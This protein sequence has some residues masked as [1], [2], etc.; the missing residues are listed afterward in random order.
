M[1][2]NNVPNENTP[3]PYYDFSKALM[4]G[5]AGGD[6]LNDAA[7]RNLKVQMPPMDT[8]AKTIRKK[9]P[10]I[11]DQVIGDYYK[12][13]N[14]SFMQFQNGQYNAMLTNFDWLPDTQENRRQS[15]E[16]V[17]HG[18]VTPMPTDP[19][20]TQTPIGTIKTKTFDQAQSNQMVF[21]DNGI[22]KP[23]SE[24]GA[25]GKP[26]MGK[27]GDGIN[28][29][30]HYWETINDQ[31]AEY[32]DPT[33]MQTV[34]GDRTM[35]SNILGTIGRSVWSGSVPFVAKGVAGL[36]GG[37]NDLWD[38]MAGKHEESGS[39]MAAKQLMNWGNWNSHMN[40]D[41]QTGASGFLYSVGSIAGMIVT[42]WGVSGLIGG[43][44]KVGNI[45]AGAATAE[46]LGTEGAATMLGE[47][48][49]LKYAGKAFQKTATEKMVQRVNMG[50]MSTELASGAT[51]KMNMMGI[52][53]PKERALVY[54]PTLL[55]MYG[56]MKIL[57]AKIIP[58]AF[59]AE[60]RA[61]A[62]AEMKAI[63]GEPIVKTVLEKGTSNT[64]KE[65]IGK[66]IANSVLGIGG[67]IKKTAE[68]S[69]LGKLAMTPVE[70]TITV[71]AMGV[72]NYA[73]ETVYNTI[74]DRQSKNIISSLGNNEYKTREVEYG[75]PD[76]DGNKRTRTE[77]YKT[78]SLGTETIM[79]QEL[80]EAE[81]SDIASA[82]NFLEGPGKFNPTENLDV[83]G[84]GAPIVAS[85]LSV[86][87][88]ELFNAFKAKKNIEQKRTI[89]NLA[90][91]FL[92]DP[93]A[94]ADWKSRLKGVDLWETYVDAEGQTITSD[95][96]GKVPSY[97]EVMKQDL[98]NRIEYKMEIIRKYGLLGSEATS[99]STFD[100][101][102]ETAGKT[103]ELL[104][105]YEKQKE[106]HQ[107]LVDEKADEK[108]VIKSQE[109]LDSYKKDID[110]HMNPKD[111]SKGMT[112]SQ[113]Y[114]DAVNDKTRFNNFLDTIAK[115]RAESRMRAELTD[116]DGKIDLME[117]DRQAKFE[118]SRIIGSGNV[119]KFFYDE[120]KK[121]FGGHYFDR[122]HKEMSNYFDKYHEVVNKFNESK[123]VTDTDKYSQSIEKLN[124]FMDDLSSY[125][126]FQRDSK[127]NVVLNPE[128][129]A[130]LSD[131]G[132]MPTSVDEYRS[133]MEVV[134][135]NIK[136]RI[137]EFRHT[138]SL[139]DN[140]PI[141]DLVEKYKNIITEHS[142]NLEDASDDIDIMGTLN[143]LSG[144]GG[145][146]TTHTEVLSKLDLSKVEKMS[147]FKEMP[148]GPE[149]E[150][151]YFE[152]I[153]KLINQVPVAET[154]GVGYG[155][156]YID[157][158]HASA[159]TSADPDRIIENLMG[160][161]LTGQIGLK[162]KLTLFK[163][164]LEENRKLWQDKI[165]PSKKDWQYSP[166]HDHPQTRI[167]NENYDKVMKRIDELDN[168]IETTVLSLADRV[169]TRDLRDMKEGMA[170]FSMDHAALKILIEHD[171]VLLK[172]ASENVRNLIYGGYEKVNK[173]F[174]DLLTKYKVDLGS[175]ND[176]SLLRKL[177]ELFR[178]ESPDNEAK[179]QDIRE[180]YNEASKIMV[181]TYDQLGNGKLS[182]VIDNIIAN[183]KNQSGIFWYK[184]DGSNKG[185]HRAYNDNHPKSNIIPIIEDVNQW[186]G[187]NTGDALDLKYENAAY[188][189]RAWYMMT[190]L[191]RINMAGKDGSPTYKQG[192]Q[193][194]R[195]I[196]EAGKG[197][198]IPNSGQEQAIL[199][200]FMHHYNPV[201]VHLDKL[202][203]LESK[204]FQKD[205]IPG[206]IEVNGY[207]SAGKT[208][209]IPRT[210]LKMIQ[211]FDGYTDEPGNRIK[212][213]VV[214]PTEDLI[215]TH[216]KNLGD[217]KFVDLSIQT[218][219]EFNQSKGTKQTR[220]DFDILIVDEGSLTTKSTLTDIK[221]NIDGNIPKL[222]LADD[223]Q[224]SAVP[225]ILLP[226]DRIGE[227][228]KAVTQL[229][230]SGVDQLHYLFD[231]IRTIRYNPEAKTVLANKKFFYDKSDPRN[232]LGV[233]F[234]K[235]L[236]TVKINF[237]AYLESNPNAT[238]EDAILIVRT[239][240]ERNDVLAEINP[241]DNLTKYSAMVKTM[242]VVDAKETHICS[243][244][245]S[246]NVFLAADII[247]DLVKSNR[248]S[249]T[250]TAVRNG[251][252]TAPRAK[253]YINTIGETKNTEESKG[254]VN[255]LEDTTAVSKGTGYDKLRKNTLDRLN[256]ISGK[257]SYKVNDITPDVDVADNGN[258]KSFNHSTQLYDPSK[259][260]IKDT[261]QEKILKRQHGDP[262]SN[263]E[264]TTS[265]STL[266]WKLF[267]NGE[268]MDPINEE[269]KARNEV[270]R[271]VYNH[272]FDP[273]AENKDSN[274]EKLISFIDD[275][276]DAMNIDDP[277]GY[278]IML[279]RLFRHS[280]I[281]EAIEGTKGESRHLSFYNSYLK[282]DSN[283]EDGSK[284]SGTPFA[285]KVVG[286]TPE[287]KFIVDVYDIN[288][289]RSGSESSL[290]TMSEYNKLKLGMYAGQLMSEDFVVN[291]L[292]VFNV[293]LE[294]IG[295]GAGLSPRIRT[296]RMAFSD[297]KEN[298]RDAIIEKFKLSFKDYEDRIS[299][300]E[301]LYSEDRIVEDE[302][303][304]LVGT[305]WMSNDG[306]GRKSIDAIVMGSVG[307]NG[308]IGKFVMSGN[309]RIPYEVFKANHKVEIVEHPNY[310][311]S[312][313][314]RFA[315]DGVDIGLTPTHNVAS[316]VELINLYPDTKDIWSTKNP[317]IQLKLAIGKYMLNQPVEMFYEFNREGYAP[318]KEGNGFETKTFMH[319]VMMRIPDARIPEV[320]NNPT[321]RPILEKLGITSAKFNKKMGLISKIE[322]DLFIDKGVV[323]LGR[324][325]DIAEKVKLQ[326]KLNTKEM[327]IFTDKTKEVNEII[328]NGVKDVSM[329]ES[330]K[331]F[332]AHGLHIV[333]NASL[334]EYK[335][336]DRNSSLTP[337]NAVKIPDERILRFL[338]SN[339][340]ARDLVEKELS[341]FDNDPSD[342]IR[343]N[344]IDMNVERLENM[345]D[346]YRMRNDTD[347]S[348][349]TTINDVTTGNAI[350]DKESKY[351]INDVKKDAK[352]HGYTFD[353]NN[354]VRNIVPSEAGMTKPKSI[355]FYTNVS[356][357]GYDTPEKV[358]F[359]GAVADI[360]YVR[361]ILADLKVEAKKLDDFEKQYE[362][363]EAFLN[364]R[365]MILAA[366]NNTEAFKFID[367]NVFHMQKD[368]H[369]IIPNSFLENYIT[370]D[371]GRAYITGAKVAQRVQSIN[372]IL[373]EIVARMESDIQSGV[374]DGFTSK[375]YKPVFKDPFMKGSE[376][377]SSKNLI[378]DNLTTRFK[379]LSLP[380]VWSD[381][382]KGAGTGEITDTKR[383]EVEPVD[384]TL[385]PD[386][387]ELFEKVGKKSISEYEFM[388]LDNA[389]AK[390]K[391][392]I[393]NREINTEFI[394]EKL[395]DSNDPLKFGRVQNALVTLNTY[396]HD[397]NNVE[398]NTPRHEAIHYILAYLV[399]PEM[400]TKIM[401][402]ARD[403]MM[404]NGETDTSF[405]AIHEYLSNGFE[406]Y[407]KPTSVWGRFSNWV[408]DMLARVGLY[409]H[410]KNSF[411]YSVENG[412]YT[413]SPIIRGLG[414]DETFN[415]EEKQDPHGSVEK[416]R[417][418]EKIF[419]NQYHL[420]EVAGKVTN[421]W[422]KHSPV[423]NE[424]DKKYFS[425]GI[426]DSLAA[427]YKE[428]HDQYQ[429]N[430]EMS[431]D[432]FKRGYDNVTY[433][434]SEGVATYLNVDK[435]NNPIP[436]HISEVTPE[437]FNVAMN[438]PDK[439]NN[440]KIISR[441]MIHQLGVSE[442]VFRTVMKTVMQ[443][444][445]L[446]KICRVANE[447]IAQEEVMRGE[448]MNPDE[449]E[450]FRTEYG[451]KK[452]NSSA[453]ETNYRK[454]AGLLMNTL[455]NNVPL[456]KAILTD[457]GKDGRRLTGVE[458]LAPKDRRYISENDIIREIDRAVS[459]FR[460]EGNP[461]DS[462][463]D[464]KLFDI[465]E[466][467]ASNAPSKRV[468]DVIS[469]FLAVYG[470]TPWMEKGKDGDVPRVGTHYYVDIAR[471][472]GTEV[473]KDM[474]VGKNNLSL[475]K[476]V[477]RYYGS[478][479]E[480]YAERRLNQMKDISAGIINYV[481]A[482]TLRD[483][484]SVK[485]TGS[486]DNGT[487]KVTMNIFTSG[488]KD[489]KKDKL[490]LDVRETLMTGDT[491]N[492]SV[493][494]DFTGKESKYKVDK[495]GV[496]VFVGNQYEPV[497]VKQDGKNYVPF[498]IK[499]KNY[500]I[501]AN[502]VCDGIH[503]IMQYVGMKDVTLA[504]VRSYKKSP[505]RLNAL[506]NSAYHWMLGIKVSVGKDE[507]FRKDR[508]L[509]D[510]L[511]NDKYKNDP[512]NTTNYQDYNTLMNYV[513][514]NKA[515]AQTYD[516][517]LNK[518]ST[519]IEKTGIGYFLPN[520]F[521]G[522]IKDIADTVLNH[523]SGPANNMFKDFA[524]N[525]HYTKVT[526]S[527]FTDLF[528]NG[529]GP[530]VQ[531]KTSRQLEAHTLNPDLQIPLSSKEGGLVKFHNAV[532]NGIINFEA[533]RSFAEIENTNG[534]AAFKNMSEGDIY[535]T[536]ID[537]NYH[538][539]FN[540]SKGQLPIMTIP[541]ADK[542]NIWWSMVTHKVDGVEMS[543]ASRKGDSLSLNHRVLSELHKNQVEFF[544][545][546]RETSMNEVLK[547]LKG[548]TNYQTAEGIKKIADIE[549]I[550]D[551]TKKAKAIDDVLKTISAEGEIADVL[552][553]DLTKTYHY[554]ETKNTKGEKVLTLG[555]AL[556]SDQVMWKDSFKKDFD[557][558][559][560]DA[561]RA[562]VIEKYSQ[563]MYEQFLKGVEDSGMKMSTKA[564]KV[565]GDLSKIMFHNFMTF[566]ESIGQL[567]RGSS[568]FYD[569]M[570]D[571][572]KRAA[573]FVAPRSTFS[574]SDEF[575][576][577]SKVVVLKD[578]NGDKAHIS[579]FTNEESV[580]A[581]HTDGDS[582]MNPVDYIRLERAAGGKIGS[583]TKGSVKTVNFYYDSEANK[584]IYF[585]FAQYPLTFFD[586]RNSQYKQ[587]MLK[588]MIGEENWNLHKDMILKDEW[589]FNVAMK[590]MAKPENYNTS[591]HISYI[592]HP[593]SFKSG[594]HGI[595]SMETKD[596]SPVVTMDN[597]MIPYEVR[598]KA[599]E[600]KNTSYGLQQITTQD[601]YNAKKTIATQLLYIV[602]VLPEN[603][604]IVQRINVAVNGF[605][606]MQINKLNSI[607]TKEELSQFVRDLNVKMLNRETNKAKSL[608]RDSSIDGYAYSKKVYQSIVDEMNNFIRPD[609]PGQSYTHEAGSHKVYIDKEGIPYLSQDLGTEHDGIDI[610][611]YITRRLNPALYYVKEDNGS[612]SYIKNRVDLENF[613]QSGR[614]LVYQPA[615]VAM[616]FN[617]KSEFGIGMKST[618]MD[619]M[620]VGDA[621][622]NTNLY[623]VRNRWDENS[624]PI[625]MSYDEYKAKLDTFFTDEKN[626]LN[627]LK[628]FNPD[629]RRVLEK[630]ANIDLNELKEYETEKQNYSRNDELMK[631]VVLSEAA[632]YYD[633]L[634]RALDVMVIRIPTA[635]GS[636][637]FMGRITSFLN[638]SAN[639][640]ITAAEKNILDGTD[641]DADQLQ[642]FFR[643]IDGKGSV[644]NIDE[645]KRNQNSIF[646]AIEDFYHN[647][648]SHTLILNKIDKQQII[649][650]AKQVLEK[651]T[652]YANEIYSSVHVG[653]IN[654]TNLQG[655]MA[656]MQNVLSRM[657]SI[658][659]DKK[660]VIFQKK[661]N[662]MHNDALIPETMDVSNT[663][664]QAAVDNATLGG[665]LN[666]INFNQATTGT[667]AGMLLYHPTSEPLLKSLFDNITDHPAMQ[668]AAKKVLDN[669]SIF[670]RGT[671]VWHELNKLLVNQE[672]KIETLNRYQKNLEK[673]MTNSEANKD[674]IEN[675]QELIDNLK[676]N[677][678]FVV[679]GENYYIGGKNVETKGNIVSNKDIIKFMDYAAAGEAI[680][681]S[682]DFISIQ[683]KG[684]PNDLPG[685]L[686]LKDTLEK[687]LG[688]SLE[689]YIND[690]TVRDSTY[691]I[692][693]QMSYLTTDKMKYSIDNPGLRE[694]EMAVRGAFNL[695]MF[696][697]AQENIMSYVRA[698]DVSLKTAYKI[699]PVHELFYGDA[700]DSMRN[701]VRDITTKEWKY[702]DDF[703][704]YVNMMND[705]L[706]SGFLSDKFQDFYFQDRP[707]DLSNGKQRTWFVL[708]APA[709]LDELKRDFPENTFIQNI[710]TGVTRYENFK[711]LELNNSKQLKP[712]ELSMINNG[713]KDL[714][715]HVQEFFRVY[716]FVVSGL[717]FKHGS[718][719][720]AM[721]TSLE[722]RY[723]DWAN[724]LN[725]DQVRKNLTSDNSKLLISGLIRYDG[726]IE[727]KNV[728][729]ARGAKVF[730]ENYGKDSMP[731]V[732]INDGTEDGKEIN[733][734]YIRWMNGV[735]ENMYYTEHPVLNNVSFETMKD[736]QDIRDGSDEYGHVYVRYSD[737]VKYI[738]DGSI[739]A[740]RD[741]SRVLMHKEYQENKK[742]MLSPMDT[743][744][745]VLSASVSYDN[746]SHAADF[747]EL[748]KDKIQKAFPNVRMEAVNNET[749][750][751]K[752]LF[753][754]IKDGVVYYN[755]DKVE[756]NHMFH[757]VVGHMMVDVLATDNPELY[758]SFQQQAVKMI[759]SGNPFMEQLLNSPAYKNLSKQGLIKEVIA[760][761]VDF[762]SAERIKLFFE[763]KGLE[764]KDSDALNI[765]QSNK[766]II[767]KVW[768]WVKSVFGKIFN[769]PGLVTDKINPEMTIQEFAKVM[770]DHILA[771]KGELSKIS[772]KEYGEI[773]N[774]DDIT[775]NNLANVYA[776]ALPVDGIKTLTEY[777]DYFRNDLFTRESDYTQKEKEDRIRVS[778]KG[779]GDRLSRKF[780]SAKEYRDMDFKGL[781][782][783]ERENRI[784][785]IASKWMP[786]EETELHNN[787][788]EIFVT[789]KGDISK[790]SEIWKT[791]DKDVH[792][793]IETE[794]IMPQHVLS[795]LMGAMNYN[796]WSDMLNYNE[797][798]S[799]D[800]YKGLFSEN[801]KTK[802]NP[803]VTIVKEGSGDLFVSLYD[804]TSDYIKSP[805]DQAKQSMYNRLYKPGEVR[806]KGLASDNS[807]GSLRLQN[808]AIIAQDMMRKNPKVQ[809][810][811]MGVIQMRSTGIVEM[812]AHPQDL[813]KELRTLA[814]DKK[815]QAILHK[816]TMGGLLDF[817]NIKPFS[818]DSRKYMLNT[819]NNDK[820]KPIWMARKLSSTDVLSVADEINI[821][822]SRV[823]DIMK[824]AIDKNTG[825]L[826]PEKLSYAQI[827]E[828]KNI[829][830][831]ITTL[832][833]T[834][835]MDFQMNSSR[836]INGFNL[837]FEPSLGIENE[838]F[839]TLRTKQLDVSN[840]IIDE[841]Q[842]YK[843]KM[844]PIWEKFISMY[845]SKDSSAILKKRAFEL[846]NKYYKDVLV[847]RKD[848]DGKEYNSQW[849]YFT[850]DEK[851]FDKDDLN[852]EHAV[853]AKQ[854]G[855]SDE[856]LKMG[857]Q[858]ADIID[859][860]MI[861][862]YRNDRW[863]KGIDYSSI[864]KKTYEKMTDAEIMAELQK[865]SSYRRGMLPIMPMKQGEMMG[866]GRGK[867]WMA[868]E[869]KKLSTSFTIYDEMSDTTREDSTRSDLLADSFIYQFGLDATERTTMG[870]QARLKM[871]GIRHDPLTGKY[872]I[873]DSEA[874]MKVSKDLEATMNYFTSSVVRKIHYEQ[875]FMPY[876]NLV[877]CLAYDMKANKGMETKGLEKYIDL[878]VDGAV[879]GKRQI[880]NGAIPGVNIKLDP[881]FTGLS[882]ITRTIVL[883]GNVNV[884]IMTGMSNLLRTISEGVANS[885]VDKGIAQGPH[886][887]KAMKLYATEYSR[888]TAWA[889]K[890]AI[891]NKSETDQLHYRGSERK[892]RK[893]IVGERNILSNHTSSM[894]VRNTDN[895]SRTIGMIAQML[896]DGSWDAHQIDKNG[897]TV[898]KKELDKRWKQKDGNVLYDEF[899]K[900]ISK[901]FD[902]LDE[903]GNM[904]KGYD[905]Q[906]ARL[907]TVIGDK[908]TVS[909]AQNPKVKA[910]LTQ[911]TLGRQFNMLHTFIWTLANNALEHGKYMPDAARR[912][913]KYDKE[914]KPITEMERF[915]T[916]GYVT[917]LLQGLKM[918][919]YAKGNFGEAFDALKTTEP[920]RYKVMKSN[921]IKI[922]TMAS[923]YLIM[924]L[925]YNG[926]VDEKE[927]EGKPAQKL[928]GDAGGSVPGYRLLRN[929]KYAYQ[930]LFFV[931]FLVETMDS[932]WVAFDF[933]KRGFV[934]RYGEKKM[935]NLM[936][937]FPWKSSYEALSEPLKENE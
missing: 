787:I 84:L 94:Y 133:N 182:N 399:K 529:S 490:K 236:E 691:D 177:Y 924:A 161:P 928:F 572:I 109:I 655:H 131:E 332:K 274:L 541:F 830:N 818:I 921:M 640:I 245:E 122:I 485:F 773:M 412:A 92:R 845:E 643:A 544:A 613:V 768:D 466:D 817:S 590:E 846:T 398:K 760:N 231:S 407:Q 494:N 843:D 878:W 475:G 602:G 154:N 741:G 42:S 877:K 634:N 87:G 638:D 158:V 862:A 856:V 335:F 190:M 853:M 923:T 508:T 117:L 95:K 369:K 788:K 468:A 418:A 723:S 355:E 704:N 535:K 690:P 241:K 657:M 16:R 420:S 430:M 455:M 233:E 269:S 807:V 434:D 726:L 309:E 232:P 188:P 922:A 270:F 506:A 147:P 135:S 209:V 374:K 64:T 933:L 778:L 711:Y 792:G 823:R 536:L 153:D 249:E 176:T 495:N 275:R 909:E 644:E 208:T 612:Y 908:W 575:R 320:M 57:P 264:E 780:S 776:A 831:I 221:N 547:S 60:A 848:A 516:E 443:D 150:Q 423:S 250:V 201:N 509:T 696:I 180:A 880:W 38:W 431:G 717:N 540:D 589:S 622:N 170:H 731:R 685:L 628:K 639:T 85:L 714:P 570:T 91:K 588:M 890:F 550:S 917:S 761:L 367:H 401:E 65:T 759:E 315:N 597:A 734:P 54:F 661:M 769:V 381:V 93:K 488:E 271:M 651:S 162:D 370:V 46:M 592:V 172:D 810:K 387:N 21:K 470:K 71:G 484:V 89:T 766:T 86:G 408:K 31:N 633:S 653:S 312:T 739:V 631:E 663:L 493:I 318:N 603:K 128:G 774:K 192:Y 366:F 720:D 289:H 910:M 23:M 137:E 708:E 171:G 379:T 497:L 302:K 61:E 72:G 480:K 860:L 718:F 239:E 107:K 479:D 770:T 784:T 614:Q 217:L 556:T 313:S 779:S 905:Y 248:E 43:I 35:S 293:Q 866:A 555:N 891:I 809:I 852:Y 500:D 328:A 667:I 916:E 397:K 882:S 230:R 14:S 433:V 841:V 701:I 30:F 104:E 330:I 112:K 267:S 259:I 456:R 426:G 716:N 255:I 886:F 388:K 609:M 868:R 235:D 486:E 62:N 814:G 574:I 931:P 108:E 678:D 224:P 743:D 799:H 813:V 756:P 22:W 919:W 901:D 467:M 537:T 1:T 349:T 203:G 282:V 105:K 351:T 45:G 234:S 805:E 520:I 50:I 591:D 735:G 582:K 58:G 502:I 77:Y 722:M 824:N 553:Y 357:E 750:F 581:L 513:D 654:R 13:I 169:R 707:Y 391:R 15:P 858:I 543:L 146:L 746:R 375:L 808:L 709:Y 885:Y 546:E 505:K 660:E 350:L 626:V 11:N 277:K 730:R 786:G 202:M 12:E 10:D 545:R 725:V 2:N 376:K 598:N 719:T 47:S 199:H 797:L 679:N 512:D 458:N 812:T 554:K 111:P 571:N 392:Y 207:A 584:L 694:Y 801:M 159:K 441:Y 837:L 160:D 285:V 113:A 517:G 227:S 298:D 567:G 833:K 887:L 825:K 794:E 191:S 305:N 27:D 800:E 389:K 647:P 871:L 842:S 606:D 325:V 702:E 383:V 695:P 700:K 343:K 196:I 737:A 83:S 118:K 872:L 748:M 777:E 48:A 134:L 762:T 200:L 138:E 514:S 155:G 478:M 874:N 698:L 527:A 840:M 358:I 152:M 636:S 197:E 832:D 487:S 736:I 384:E 51:E 558:V 548:L 372:I 29:P 97:D 596:G 438:N 789:H 121:Y 895:A 53:D 883:F 123:G 359:N 822:N 489:I 732:R 462:L 90:I 619:V 715:P 526:P 896:Y 474:L 876:A 382:K 339:E 187:A 802:H 256:T 677:P 127:G 604:D 422:Y 881:L 861:D 314:L 32:L 492:E 533:T 210:L 481:K 78:T 141:L 551:H 449:I 531:F 721:D 18:I 310:A 49:A 380:N 278:A 932:P 144:D 473:A 7:R 68:K 637:A 747:I 34:F 668:Y 120:Y 835:L 411:Y 542:P 96:D 291:N 911:Y 363:K 452:L 139:T 272:V 338:E 926:L 242:E 772:S 753:A 450:I 416:I 624:K 413:D 561:E 483:Y 268:T 24:L 686:K 658:P 198:I 632:K 409:K 400:A 839:Q 124:S 865:N 346:L 280:Q 504:M 226:V 20:F 879:K 608:L 364:E 912:V 195:D 573:G 251:I 74:K 439:G 790:T 648:A 642:V 321:V 323:S 519:G 585:K 816:D 436:F 19:M 869:K 148:E 373:E 621:L 115:K 593:S 167:S 594:A 324:L 937:F 884:A 469:S 534:G 828:L 345:R 288:F 607:Q 368:F 656:L 595:Q 525:N 888:S 850:K 605:V 451:N 299:T 806:L 55:A 228:T 836:D 294:K 360:A 650:K 625:K 151:R 620:R 635:N 683:G 174:E 222:F 395:M 258:G 37:Y 713:W 491:L 699:M 914:G 186:F 764:I 281:V 461:I 785:D 524:G 114:I 472:Y 442:D 205:Y 518:A 79:D 326:K 538:F 798:A 851:Q 913:L 676:N 110:Y 496:E 243:G 80:W 140:K 645:Y 103:I 559:T 733:S 445:N 284:I 930:S 738:K 365:D 440:K 507:I 577:T 775:L 342:A 854:K 925:L 446:D 863:T 498:D 751:N 331:R 402:S 659:S 649:D 742:I 354:I 344:L 130:I 211:S 292:N 870:G 771:E 179:Q 185:I 936:N 847:T 437:M 528:N 300:Y 296:M 521:Y 463:T 578:I 499:D 59:G 156:N 834:P 755:T 610:D 311:K 394:D 692:A 178:A 927:N 415:K 181:D 859:K 454:G 793:V 244:I 73:V 106:A 728:A 763:G 669:T 143:A 758:R 262:E 126:K 724:K 168:K 641:Y 503:E 70:T 767:Q 189:T 898:Y 566:N 306:S 569:G 3:Q 617:H 754:Y 827:D 782:P 125:Y 630:R 286:K 894:L 116:K 421:L 301:K 356:R 254:S 427:T 425:I 687:D 175:S 902:G 385:G 240:K 145:V 821:W 317:G 627:I 377:Y 855:I 897:K 206:A 934:G 826:I 563:P 88:R 918:I 40:E 530:V 136:N 815:Y 444:Y 414:S 273:K 33:R 681:R 757:E 583:I 4:A 164:Q 238:R 532:L 246:K 295:K 670:K 63:F 173:I 796:T 435:D 600:I 429:F 906:T 849:L 523:S 81:K 257:S 515:E 705:H 857:G 102:G 448:K 390:I 697:G 297:M 564:E 689:N 464:D 432:K 476:D 56:S 26:L 873:L 568:S 457:T 557:K 336:T 98:I 348:L 907:F 149:K 44:A 322:Y 329:E 539:I 460:N 36:L 216:Q 712:A 304:V 672:G 340:S 378:I 510:D 616:P 404:K 184:E 749:S 465:L 5:Y 864:A 129:K 752:D 308:Q 646:D 710:T 459:K 623:D 744:G 675:Q 237:K 333:A 552:K 410:D 166:L 611:G 565:W 41:E 316:H 674:K 218:N 260:S 165:E 119:Y 76:A 253:R 276:K 844:I 194:L 327:E 163:I 266:A 893:Q 727:S 664:I 352:L 522:D 361:D 52:T 223:S 25:T 680:R 393:G 67:K 682:A 447:M 6:I 935:E 765:L 193:T 428:I 703:K 265:V 783:Q 337:G 803:F 453:E 665:A 319:S 8:F 362:S 261:D 899:K 740:L 424:V 225:T 9:N 39:D 684:L 396:G 580:K 615:E 471:K 215:T 287:G 599:L 804:V 791:I 183:N 290:N 501:R 560:T 673:L 477:K 406:S 157:Q 142:K 17:A 279:M 745:H 417:E 889:D 618:L 247:G 482:T 371:K 662:L 101:D 811:D 334:P 693:K 69:V 819:Y 220:A 688:R 419:G 100:I 252:L 904:T 347:N 920:E 587:S 405:K 28:A 511:I 795:D 66:R 586:V 706:A 263:G 820:S 652:F 729:K 601:V 229:Y 341:A 353:E 303:D 549:K 283:L 900:Q 132:V 781:S 838:F 629:V 579:Q 867:D 212:V 666:V 204:E 75:L 829:M 892:G 903:S 915:Y 929:T 875:D 671:D 576:P 82:K 562:S 307:T 99:E 386:G 403:E 214:V 213:R 219:Y